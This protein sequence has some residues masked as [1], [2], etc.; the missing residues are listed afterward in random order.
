MLKLILGE[1][2]YD[3]TRVDKSLLIT[4]GKGANKPGQA[5]IQDRSSPTFG[6]IIIFNFS[7][8]GKCIYLFEAHSFFKKYHSLPLIAKTLT[9]I[10]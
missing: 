9:M 1:E 5:K 4:A 3:V 8:S 10:E 7:H 6:V 2:F